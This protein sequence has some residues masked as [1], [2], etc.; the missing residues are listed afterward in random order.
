MSRSSYLPPSLLVKAYQDGCKFFV[1][2]L[3]LTTQPSIT[4]NCTLFSS[5]KFQSF[6]KLHFPA[7]NVIC[8]TITNRFVLQ[9]L[10]S[11]EKS[12][13]NHEHSLAL[14]AEETKKLLKRDS[15]LFIPI[16]S[17]RDAQATIVSASLLHKLYGYKLV[18]L[19]PLLGMKVTSIISVLLIPKAVGYSSEIRSSLEIL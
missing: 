13:T 18:R 4:C 14:L 3:I 17:Q 5:K 19:Y 8:V 12:E 7:L 10:H 16:L 9:V 11:V 1:N 15:S 6:N 2:N